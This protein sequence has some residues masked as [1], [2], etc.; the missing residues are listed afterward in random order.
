MLPQNDLYY[1]LASHV[2]QEFRISDQPRLGRT[3]RVILVSSQKIMIGG[4]GHSDKRTS[5]SQVRPVLIHVQ[6]FMFPCF[7]F[8]LDRLRVFTFHYIFNHF[9]C[10]KA[11]PIF[12]P[13]HPTD[14]QRWRPPLTSPGTHSFATYETRWRMV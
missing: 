11:Q 14:S 6:S 7:R 13:D 3:A 5:L 4:V 2:D 8:P 1:L 9:S 12:N 10:E